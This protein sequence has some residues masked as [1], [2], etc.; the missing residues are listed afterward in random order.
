[1]LRVLLDREKTNGGGA[2]HRALVFVVIKS[3]SLLMR[4]VTLRYGRVLP[5]VGAV[6][7]KKATTAARS[8]FLL[9]DGVGWTARET[10]AAA[11]IAYLSNIIRKKCVIVLL[12]STCDGYAREN[13]YYIIMLLFI[14]IHTYKDKYMRLKLN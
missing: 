3:S 14:V 10:A 8:R 1:V 2:G 6:E 5:N 7:T 9:R 13:G 4:P 11:V 12:S